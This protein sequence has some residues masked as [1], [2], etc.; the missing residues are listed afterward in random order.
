MATALTP[1]L[2]LRG[3]VIFV[4]ISL[5]GYIAVLLYGNNLPA[6][7]AAIGRV[8]WG[9]IVV[10]MGL[11]SLDWIG[12]GIR[13]WVLVREVHPKPSLKGLILA[14][15]M[16]AWA[17]YLTPF[18]SGSAPMTIYTMRRYGIPTGVAL[19]TT[20]LSFVATVA[21]FAIAGPIAILAGAGKALGEK[22]AILGLSLYDLF[23]G[24]LGMFVGLGLLL[25]AVIIFPRHMS[26]LVHRLAGWAGRRSTRIERKLETVRGSIDQAHQAITIFN[27][28]RGWLSI[29]LATIISA[30]SHANKLLAGYVAMRAVGIEA[31]LVDILLVQT[32]IT[33]LLYFFA[34]TPGNS[35][36]AEVLSALI[37][38]S[39]VPKSL[40]PLYT[41]IWRCILSYFTIAFGFFVFSRWVHHRLRGEADLDGTDQVIAA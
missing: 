3:L 37:M 6:F 36:I 17:S 30:P 41:L 28:P 32:L 12:G 20:L 18:Q 14:G 33:F 29:F 39:Y 16:G 35:G 27:T 25:L 21:F 9:W 38:A 34:P 2:L 40:T 23:L 8:H 10:G 15:G 7:I 5:A 1:R 19:T 31:N 13:L 26:N 4:L 22:N 24:S 11:A